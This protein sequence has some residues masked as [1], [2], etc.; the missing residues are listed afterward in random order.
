MTDNDE[1]TPAPEKFDLEAFPENLLIHERRNVWSYR[2]VVGGHFRQGERPKPP[3]TPGS[4]VKKERRRRVDPTTFEKQYTE[5]EIEF[6]NAMQQ[7]KSQTG[8]SFPT[9]DEVLKVAAGLGY[10]KVKGAR[11]LPGKNGSSE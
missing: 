2:G 7:F 5:D 9:Y 11:P 3:G 6:M 1:T 8:R 10:R 4:P